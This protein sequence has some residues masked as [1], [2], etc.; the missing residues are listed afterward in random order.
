MIPPTRILAAATVLLFICSLVIDGLRLYYSDV[1]T[2]GGGGVNGD[3]KDGGN[4]GGDNGETSSFS[5]ESLSQQLAML[6]GRK[7]LFSTKKSSRRK[8]K[9]RKKGEGEA[10]DALLDELVHDGTAGAAAADEGGDRTLEEALEEM[11]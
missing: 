3:A 2:N 9:K 5:R 1:G 4:S 8:K 7:D 10:E 11:R 6:R